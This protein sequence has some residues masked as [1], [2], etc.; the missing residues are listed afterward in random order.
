MVTLTLTSDD[1]GKLGLVKHA[2]LSKCLI[3]ANP[4]TSKHM[5]QVWS[6][7]GTKQVHAH[8]CVCVCVCDPYNFHLVSICGITTMCRIQELKEEMTAQS[9]YEKPSCSALER[10]CLQ[11]GVSSFDLN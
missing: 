5:S 11:P 7:V 4:F 3:Q 6:R 1:S 2:V 10:T 9:L 8:M